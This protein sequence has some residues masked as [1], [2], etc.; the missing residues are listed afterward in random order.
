MIQRTLTLRPLQFLILGILHSNCV[1][2]L[3]CY[4]SDSLLNQT[5]I[6]GSH[7]GFNGY[8]YI[9]INEY[10]TQATACDTKSAAICYPVALLDS[11]EYPIGGQATYNSQN[12]VM[13]E[14]GVWIGLGPCVPRVI[15]SSGVSGNM[16]VSGSG[17]RRNNDCEDLG[18]DV[19]LEELGRRGVQVT[20]TTKTKKSM[21][22]KKTTTTKTK[23]T[24]TTSTL[25]PTPTMFA[26]ANCYFLHSLPKSTQITILTALQAA[27]VHTIRIIITSFYQN[28]KGTDSLG[29]T[30][31]ELGAIGEYN[32]GILQQIDALMATALQYRIKLQITLHDRWNLDSTYGICDAYCQAFCNGGK[33]LQGFYNN[34]LADTAFDARTAHIL[35]HKNPYLGNRAWK[36]IPEAIHAFEIQN[37]AQG[38]SNGINQFTNPDWWCSRATEVRKLLGKANRIL[39]STGGGQD[40]AH[41]LVEQNFACKD[42]DIVAM[43]SYKNDITDLTVN[44]NLSAQLGKLHGK[45]VY[46][47]EFGAMT[48][49]GAWIAQV[50]QVANKLK[51]PWMPWGVSSVSINNDYEFWTDDWNTWGLF[52][53]YS[54]AAL[55]Y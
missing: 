5:L 46:L 33:D 45:R 22:T 11:A 43:H 15:T 31:L 37:D 40:F 30:D 7:A 8:N 3:G 4:P 35:T 49:K 55:L 19:V 2:A 51:I 6:Q 38:T 27:K 1:L 36:D 29:S 14:F 47:G 42:V 10:W 54:Q 32:D 12:F 53:Q 13:T 16:T 52:S 34:I 50:A 17:N 18:Y 23:T 9:R 48:G 41:S 24:V 39:V 28:G 44:L 26:G 20:T 21:T 25:L